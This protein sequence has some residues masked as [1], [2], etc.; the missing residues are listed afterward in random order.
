[1]K[2]GH[3]MA[4]TTLVG[5]GTLNGKQFAPG[6]EA[7]ELANW[8]RRYGVSMTDEIGRIRLEGR[9]ARKDLAVSLQ[10]LGEVSETPMQADGNQLN[11]FY[12]GR[13]FE[14]TLS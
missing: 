1:M 11:G 5:L 7:A 14:V 2:R 13:A 12:Q 10:S 9:I 4:L 3:F 8:A 6:T